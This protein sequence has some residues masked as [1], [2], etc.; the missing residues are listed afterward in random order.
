MA[1]TAAAQEL[2]PRAYWPAP[3]GTNVLNL[4]YQ[5]S[6]GDI[7]TDPSLPVTG[8]D[9]KINFL[10]V[11][12]QYTFSLF[13]RTA[14][15]QLNLPYSWGTSEGFLNNEF[16][17]VDTSGYGDARAR[18]SI[19]LRGAPAMD[20]AGFQALQAD[21]KTIVGVS[22][23]LQAPTGTYDEQ[24]YLNTGANRWAV[25]PA[26]GVIWPFRPTWMFE[27]ELGAWFFGD[28]DEFVGSTREQDLIVSSEFHLVKRVGQSF[29]AS[30]DVN[31]YFGG[32]TTIDSVD[33]ADLQRNSRFGFTV[34]KSIARGHALRASYSTGVVTE[35]GGDYA[36]TALSY[37]AVW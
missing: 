20:G 34:F 22:L 17:S 31:Y 5:Y 28:N 15:A 3:V 26:A 6:S 29:W 8:V 19:N 18:L 4:G 36:I 7:V 27:A 25:K 2:A 32:R 9:S 23:L 10:Q 12:Y 21:P 37:I 14:N 30:L 35:S 1:S 13:G 24:K 16:I 33:R 11:G